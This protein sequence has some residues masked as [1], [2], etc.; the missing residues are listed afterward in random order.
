MGRF[1]RSK[2]LDIVDK[3]Y[4]G[5]GA[6]F[7]T[8]AFFQ[9]TFQ[10]F[11]LDRSSWSLW[12]GGPARTRRTT[13]NGLAIVTAVR[14]REGLCRCHAAACRRPSLSLSPYSSTAARASTIGCTHHMYRSWSAA[15]AVDLYTGGVRLLLATPEQFYCSTYARESREYLCVLHSLQLLR[16]DVGCVVPRFLGANMMVEDLPFRHSTALP[17]A[18]VNS[19]PRTSDS[20]KK[21]DPLTTVLR[22]ASSRSPRCRA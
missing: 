2:F 18:R 3:Y 13:E 14:G 9:K 16:H 12:A 19:S 6:F 4:L 22:I 20:P 11:P 7:G 1:E 8:A 17:T 5:C 10:N 15:T 21:M